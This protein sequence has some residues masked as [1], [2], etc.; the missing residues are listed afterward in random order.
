LARLILGVWHPSSGIVRLDGADVTGWPREALAPYVGYLPQD[1]ELFAATVSQNIARMGEVD[2]AA[3]IEAAQRAGVHELILS[4]PQGYDTQ[5][6]EA[7]CFLSGGQRQR[8]GLAR[9]LYGKPRLI[10]LD[11]PSANLD[12][13][14]ESALLQAM[15]EIKSVGTTL[16]VI[17]HRPSMLGLIDSMLVMNDGRIELFGPRAAVMARVSPAIAGV[18]AP[19]VAEPVRLHSQG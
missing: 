15:A 19:A 6:G 10:V 1:V 13:E 7:G 9:A 4:L 17:T 12:T 16:I 14:G 11:E 8:L 5:I 3:V 18:K 2:D